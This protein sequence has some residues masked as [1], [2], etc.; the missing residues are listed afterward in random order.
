MS[1][2]LSEL[3]NKSPDAVRLRE[4]SAL[5]ELLKTTGGRVVLFGAGSVGTRALKELRGIGIT[6]LCF[7]DNNESR[8]GS[9]IEG[10]PLLSPADAAL[11]YGADSLF[12]VTIWNAA[13]WYVET[14]AQLR[15]LG[16]KSV[17]NY[18][19][20]FWRFP[21]TFLPFLLNDLSHKVYED[22]DNVLAAEA[23]WADQVSLEAYRSHVRWYATGDASGLP[24]RPSENSYFPA[25]VFSISPDEVLVDCGAFDGDTIQQVIER[26]GSRF[27]SVHAVEA[28]PLSLEKLQRNLGKMSPDVSQK[29]KIHECAVGAERGKVRFE[30]TGTVDSKICVE[31][32]V[33]VDCIPMDE[34]FASTPVTMIKMDIEGAEYDA[35]IGGSKV[36]QRDRP[37]LA[38]CVYH[39]QSDLWR[40]P[41]L[42]QKLLPQHK[43]Y[44]RPYEG[45]GFQTV[46]YAVPPDRVTS[47]AA[48]ASAYGA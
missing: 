38:V 48:K 7:S 43:F 39:L 41:L 34:L 35:L 16:C 31:G 30:T 21:A 19:P 23:L 3:L 33:E 8:W 42:A 26:A 1:M 40:L 6:P 14:L 5:D 24:S 46:L 37:I 18:S 9:T 17:S 11:R 20:L 4:Q 10:C 2:P 47:D 28:D 12:L 44:L 22:A 29:V 36:I 32:G 13:H 27:G 45:D 15:S 25:D